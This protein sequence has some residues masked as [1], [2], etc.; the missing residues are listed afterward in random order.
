M[1][2]DWQDPNLE[3][4]VGCWISGHKV[5]GFHAGSG[6]AKEATD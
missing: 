6:K 4:N 2:V 1:I 5:L 3:V